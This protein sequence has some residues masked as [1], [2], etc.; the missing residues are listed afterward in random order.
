MFKMVIYT[1]EEVEKLVEYYN[2]DNEIVSELINDYELKDAQVAET[3]W[4]TY[5]Q[6]ELAAQRQGLKGIEYDIYSI[7]EG[8]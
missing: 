1:F 7:K 5:E 4:E 3:I 8:K 2:D 6:A